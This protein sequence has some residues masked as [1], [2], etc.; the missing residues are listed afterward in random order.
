MYGSKVVTCVGKVLDPKLFDSLDA[1]K[2]A[3]KESFKETWARAHEEGATEEYD[4]PLGRSHPPY[5]HAPEPFKL[6]MVRLGVAF[7]LGALYAWRSSSMQPVE[8]SL[9]MDAA[10]G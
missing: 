4:P 7:A 9:V 8:H 6:N 2:V 10:S 3:C 1:F 5:H